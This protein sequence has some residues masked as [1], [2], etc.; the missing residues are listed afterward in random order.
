MNKIK[1]GIIGMGNMGEGHWKNI[2][3]GHTPKVELTA[4]CDWAQTRRDWCKENLPE[5]VKIF[6]N[7]TDMMKSGLIDSVLIAVPHYDHP[8]LVM[9]ALENGLNVYNEKPAGVY[10]KQ[11]IEM[12]EAAKKSDK[13]FA[14]G[15]QQRTRTYFEKLREIIKSGQLGHIKKFVWIVTDWYRPQGYHDS[16]NWRSTWKDEGGGVIINQNPHNLDIIQWLFGMPSSLLSMCDFGKYYDIEVDD[17]VS[18]F[19]KYDNGTVGIYTTSTGEAPGT[20]RLEISCDMGKIVC[21][22]EQITFWRNVESEREFN[23]HYKGVFGRPEVWKCEIPVPPM[24]APQHARLLNNFADA[25]LNGAELVAPGPEGINEMTIS[26]AIY[27]SAWQGSKWIDL[28]NFDHEGFYKALC[29]KIENSTVVKNVDR[30]VGNTEGT[31]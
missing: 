14:I 26:N 5:T 28:K 23:K 11:V 2:K 30:K 17:D 22:N 7:A 3:N 6:D 31:Y 21:E 12:N 9:E 16:S 25:I 18:I 15:F 27:Y 20:N 10:T 4:V 13:V 19:F 29:E 1:L 24:P 8:K